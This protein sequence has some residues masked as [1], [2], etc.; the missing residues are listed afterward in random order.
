MT[1]VR[2]ID[3]ARVSDPLWPDIIPGSV[4]AV[5]L[6][7]RQTGDTLRVNGRRVV[8]YTRAP[9]IAAEELMSGRDPGLWD[10][11]VQPLDPARRR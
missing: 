10:V 3:K 8:V 5:T 9:E 1:L 11:R 6:V 7:D 2:V 4:C